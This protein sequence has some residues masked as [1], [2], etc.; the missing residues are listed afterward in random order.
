MRIVHFLCAELFD[1]VEILEIPLRIYQM[2]CLPLIFHSF[3]VSFFIQ[4]NWLQFMCFPNAAKNKNIYAALVVA[5]YLPH[6]SHAFI[7]RIQLEK[8]QTCGKIKIQLIE[9]QQ[10]RQSHC[11]SGGSSFKFISL[12][13]NVTCVG[14]WMNDCMNAFV[15]GVLV[16]RRCCS[17]M[18]F[19]S[20]IEICGINWT[21]FTMYSLWTRSGCFFSIH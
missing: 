16:L 10:L 15:D 3:L 14:Q 13:L 17:V 9:C 1:S 8:L 2:P 4:L 18:P 7:S 6:H 20:E 21:A 11:D 19:N 12:L 5:M